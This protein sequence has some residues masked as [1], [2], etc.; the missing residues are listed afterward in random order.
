MKI[1]IV[2]AKGMLGQELAGVF[3]DKKPVLWD[4]EEIDIA[5]EE[6]VQKK[7]G[8]LRQ[9]EKFRPVTSYLKLNLQA[10]ATLPRD[11][12]HALENAFANAIA[13]KITGG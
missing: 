6:D 1:L 5:N 3:Q 8:T 4:R 9:R 13:T 7:V 10:I 2:G 12:I 11:F